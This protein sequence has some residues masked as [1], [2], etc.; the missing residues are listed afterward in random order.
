MKIKQIITLAVTLPTLAA[1][2]SS[3]TEY[4]GAIYDPAEDINR[5]IL[6]FNETVDEYTLE[7]L[8]KGYRYVP[9]TI[10]TGIRNVL[11]NLDEPFNVANQILQGDFDGATN[12]AGRFVINSTI[13]LVGLIDV[14]ESEFNLEEEEEDFGQTLAVWGVSDGPYLML[15]LFGPSNARD[16]VGKVADIF[17]DPI[18][19][20]IDNEVFDIASTTLETVDDREQLIEPLE[21]LEK[22]SLDFYTAL[23][24]A[25]TQ[26]RNAEIDE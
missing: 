16:T 23:Q 8:A 9:S 25:Y 18:D 22:E 11:S 17:L 15:P 24:S 12:G 10:R 13:G 6:E 5:G 4:E 7:P 20:V 19:L 1:C 14:A 2:A 21:Q 3:K 26:R